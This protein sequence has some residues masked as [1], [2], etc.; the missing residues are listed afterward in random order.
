MRK[1]NVKLTITFLSIFAF[2][3]LSQDVA[4]ELVEY[5]VLY[6][7]YD[8]VVRLSAKKSKKTEIILTGINV[9]IVKSSDSKYIVKAGNGRTAELVVLSKQKSKIDTLY[10]KLYRV[11]EMPDPTIY[12]GASESG[13]KSKKSEKFLF[14]KYPGNVPLNATH[15]IKKWELIYGDKTISG[16]GFDLSRA[17]DLIESL[18]SGATVTIKCEVEMPTQLI[19]TI[20][21][22]W[23][24]D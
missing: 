14:A 12:W 15:S 17:K 20:Y 11:N 2:Q 7:G 23:Q 24:L 10:K 18:P 19:K 8:N 21:G 5:N 22:V 4:I 16:I 6:R 13:T 9:E 1:I 3:T